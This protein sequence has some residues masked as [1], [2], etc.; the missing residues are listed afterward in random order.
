MDTIV[1]G[2]SI[3]LTPEQV[4]KIIIESK[5]MKPPLSNLDQAR[6]WVKDFL[7]KNQS[8][9]RAEENNYSITYSLPDGWIFKSDIIN[10]IFLFSYY[11]FWDTLHSRFQLEY[12]EVQNIVRDLV[13]KRFGCEGFTP[14]VRPI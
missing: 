10:R 9:W 12:S 6:E 14:S 3:T 4:E 8:N 2:V 7:K 5:T 11:R 13:L 1:N